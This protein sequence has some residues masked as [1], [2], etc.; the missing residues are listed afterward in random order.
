MAAVDVLTTTV[1]TKEQVIFAEG[2]LA[3]HELGAGQS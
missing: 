1:S 3:T 2:N